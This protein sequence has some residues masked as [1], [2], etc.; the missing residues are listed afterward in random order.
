MITGMSTPPITAGSPEFRRI[1]R[2]MVFGGFSTFALLYCVQPLMP[3]LAH[4]FKL[5]PAQSSLALS[6]ATGTLAISLLASSVLS[7][8]F[9]RKPLMAGSMFCGGVL[10]LLAA[11]AHSYGQLLLLRALLGLLLGGMPALAMAY[12]SEEIAGPSLG[13]SMGLY[14][15]GSAFGGMTGRV[16]ASVISDFY[17]WRIAVGAMG[18]MGLYAAW[19]FNRSLPAS[20]N[21]RGGQGG[22]RA[23]VSGTARH[24]RDAGLPWLFS[25]SFLLMGV[26]VSMYNYI[27]Y[28]LLAP[29][30]GLRQSAVGALSI[31]YLLG[32]FS[33]VWAGKLADRLGRR[34]V[35]WMVMLVMLGGLLLTLSDAVLLIVI[36]MGLFTFGFFASHSVCS[37]WVGRRARPPQALASAIYLFFYYLGSSV[38][39]WVSGVV[40]AWAGWPGVVSMLGAVLLAAMAVALRLRGLAPLAPVG[41]G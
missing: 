26:F 17:D 6:V 7:E 20:T 31:L 36:G 25:L 10:T 23:L 1:N 37:S 41:A 30:F 3:L 16:L 14:I 22:W 11:F 13:H 12:L 8:R 33:S 40:W 27:G 32:I 19:E 4:D 28:R 9:G 24:V 39:G 15:G 35:L 2:A 21:F 38:V 34:N 18:A 5:T 29:S